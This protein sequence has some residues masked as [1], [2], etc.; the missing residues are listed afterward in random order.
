MLFAD[1]SVLF[2]ETREGLQNHLNLLENNCH[3]WI[4]TVSIPKAKIAVFCKDGILS[5]HDHWFY[6]GQE[7]DIVNSFTY[8]GVVF[9]QMEASLC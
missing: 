3:K 8:L 1:D 4:V 6:S 7:I 9:F 2:S 5:H